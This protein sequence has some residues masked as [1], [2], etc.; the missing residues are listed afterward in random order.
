MAIVALWMMALVNVS[1]NYYQAA[2]L[3]EPNLE[4]KGSVMKLFMSTSKVTFKCSDNAW[5]IVAYEGNPSVHI[6]STDS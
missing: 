4:V 6:C 5:Y 2:L 3:I 1:S